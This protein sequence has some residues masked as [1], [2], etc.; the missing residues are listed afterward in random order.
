MQT[1]LESRIFNGDA[2]CADIEW[3]SFLNDLFIDTALHKFA[4]S[5]MDSNNA[6]RLVRV[7]AMT[8]RYVESQ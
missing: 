1:Q 4:E 7:M 8:N 5:G 6:M 3:M 2:T